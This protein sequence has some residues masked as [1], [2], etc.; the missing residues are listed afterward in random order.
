MFNVIYFTEE[1][2]LVIAANFVTLGEV[3]GAVPTVEAM[4]V[5]QTVT[6]LPGLVLFGEHLLAHGAAGPE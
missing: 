6:D 3:R 1:V 5:E 2:A 4:D